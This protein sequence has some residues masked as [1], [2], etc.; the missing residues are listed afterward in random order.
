MPRLTHN[1]SGRFES[2]FL[3]VSIQRSPAVLL[4]GMEVTPSPACMHDIHARSHGPIVRYD[5][6]CGRAWHGMA[7]S[8]ES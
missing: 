3:T 2:R 4:Q 8:G 5:S 7:Q 1:S 6:F